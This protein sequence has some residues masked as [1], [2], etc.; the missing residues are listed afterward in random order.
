MEI[1]PKNWHNLEAPEAVISLNSSSDGL[2]QDEASLTGESVPI[3]KIS[4]PIEGEVSVGDRRNMVFMGTAAVYG[5]A[6]AIVTATGMS[7]EF[8]KIAA[9]LQEVK[10]A[11]TPL[12]INLD[13]VG[14]YIG[15]GALILS[16]VLAS[17]GVMRGHEI[18]EMFI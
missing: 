18:L 3:E 7:T 1:G 6:K 11:R 14:K 15:I 16:F 12:Q 5:R 8:G 2:S 10:A 13:R 17:L 9:M 4:D